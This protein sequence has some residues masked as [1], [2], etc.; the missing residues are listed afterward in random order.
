MEARL[1]FLFRIDRGEKEFIPAHRHQCYEL[2]YYA[3]GRGHTRIGEKEWEYEKSHY[4]VIRPLTVH[5]E[6]RREILTDVLCV[7][8][9]LHE[10]D[11][12]LP[13]GVFQDNSIDSLLPLLERMLA[14]LQ[15][16][17]PRFSRMLDLLTSELAIRLERHLS[18]EPPAPL[19]NKF[20]Y[21]LNYMNEHFTQKID[22]PSL[23][24]MA[25]YSYDRYRHLF[26]E[27]TG[28]SPVQYI[29]KKRVDYARSLLRHTA[30]SVSAI[31]MECGFS[32]D[33]QFCSVF[34]RE[35]GSTPGQYRES[36]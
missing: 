16:E 34:K 3:K 15:D 7:G 22:F 20:Q 28:Y 23:S 32:T 27:R 5:D 36:P 12:P 10:S 4:A 1:D 6:R 33:A 11:T 35:L 9:S 13:E 21:T 26:K 2:V 24:A 29:V 30:L 17:R 25:G 14:E 18:A 31:A 19:E 8:F